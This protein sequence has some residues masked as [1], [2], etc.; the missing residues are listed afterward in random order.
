MPDGEM[1]ESVLP[2]SIEK[3]EEEFR[4][5]MWIEVI[6]QTE[7]LY[8]ELVV[9]HTEVENKDRELRASKF[10]AENIIK[11]M[12]NVLV[13]LDEKGEMK[14]VNKAASDLFGYSQ[15]ELIDQKLEKLFAPEEFCKK[16]ISKSINPHESPEGVLDLESVFVTKT[17]IKIPMTF[18]CSPMRD[19]ENNIIGSVVVAQDLRKIK[20]FIKKVAKAA[21]AYRNK[22]FELAKAYKELQQL[23]NHLIQSEKLAFIGK[24]AAGIA[25]EINNPLTSVLAMSSFM[26][27]KIQKDDS[28]AGDLQII[29]EETKRCKRIVEE[30][31]EFSR[32]RE[33]ERSPA[34]V[35]RVI[36]NCL[37]VVEKQ[38]FFHN[39]KI[40]TKFEEHLPDTMV[41][42]NQIKQVFVNIILNAQEAMPEGGTLTVRTQLAADGRFVEIRFI[43]TGYGIS[44][45]DIPRLFDPFFTTKRKTKGTGLGLSISYGIVSKHGGTINV[46]SNVN[47]GSTFILKLPIE[48]GAA[49]AH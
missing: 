46:I 18:S 20:S 26:L 12:K 29:V 43:D 42:K 15:N 19:E 27:G 45:E 6:N 25:H 16:L 21:R 17:G 9:S 11:S 37:A 28:T 13:V 2:K 10:F 31:L 30:L 4:E 47:E 44:K 34:D 36:E 24:L 1:K 41:D 39:I 3:S 14:V 23:Q 5:S 48:Q 33:P 49:N 8:A 32:Q 35:N 22:A 7:R 38:H 40:V